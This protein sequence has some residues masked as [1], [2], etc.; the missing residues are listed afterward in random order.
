MNEEKKNN[1]ENNQMDI[2]TIGFVKPLSFEEAIEK[3]EIEEDEIADSKDTVIYEQNQEFVCGSK[4]NDE[5]MREKVD[6]LLEELDESEE[7]RE[8]KERKTKSKKNLFFTIGIL[9]ELAIIAS[10]A[11]NNFFKEKYYKVLNCTSEIEL[12]EENY[13]VVM[14]KKYYFDKDN[15]V[16]KLDNNIEYKF[17]DSKSYK[18]YKK[19]Y[20]SSDIKNYSGLKQNSKF[21]DKNLTYLNNTEYTYSKL[22]KNKNVK[23]D[24]N[25][26]TLKIAGRKDD[27][28][29]L[30]E[31][32]DSVVANSI[33]E[34]FACK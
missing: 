1:I 17:L 8:K 19:N 9:I 26:L 6:E 5:K 34:G 21:D 10:L 22:K 29:L 33:N 2:F 24:N 23:L 16:S 7:K 15:I 4:S 25:I 27:I 14:T 18:E 20:V 11:Y 13:K 31:S 28:T 12:K 32:Y 30:I 3:I